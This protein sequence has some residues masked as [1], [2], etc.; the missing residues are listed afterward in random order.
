[1]APSDLAPLTAADVGCVI[2][3]NS[4]LR[5]VAAAADLEIQPLVAGEGS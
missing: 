2:G 1:M 3:A 5:K 4:L